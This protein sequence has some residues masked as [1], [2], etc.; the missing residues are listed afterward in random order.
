MRGSDKCRFR[1]YSAA[2]FIFAFFT[3]CEQEPQNRPATPTEETATAAVPVPPEEPDP[4]YNEGLARVFEGEDGYGVIVTDVIWKWSPGD[5]KVIKLCWENAQSKYDEQ[6]TWVEESVKSVWGSGSKRDPETNELLPHEKQ[7]QYGSALVFVFTRYCTE[8]D[9]PTSVHI[10]IEDT[11]KSP[12]VRALGKELLGL[13]RG[14]QLNFEFDV[15]QNSCCTQLPNGWPYEDC[16]PPKDP[17]SENF[18]ARRKIYRACVK[19]TAIHEFGHVVA[20]AH[21]QKHPSTPEGC[22]N[23][24]QQQLLIAGSALEGSEAA[25]TVDYDPLSVMNYCRKDRMRALELSKLDQKTLNAIYCRKGVNTCSGYR[26]EM[27]G[28]VQ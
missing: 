1:L 2:V 13:E 19:A 6:M 22:H 12:R 20:L 28:S 24:L 3:A 17:N 5:P 25:L 10:S 16:R 23:F 7:S 4:E 15:L 27:I 18:E 26:T 9:A 14:V 8:V 21:E 11:R